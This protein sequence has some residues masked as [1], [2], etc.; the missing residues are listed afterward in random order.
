MP[1]VN[2]TKWAFKKVFDFYSSR[3]Y[4]LDEVMDC[5]IFDQIYGF[6][7][8]D[9]RQTYLISTKAFSR[10]LLLPIEN[11][12]K[13]KIYFY[14]CKNYILQIFFLMNKIRIWDQNEKK[15]HFSL[16]I[17]LFCN[18]SFFNGSRHK[19]MKHPLL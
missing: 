8:S 1:Y 12:T 2:L 9:I 13:Q 10:G 4:T 7:Q 5:H 15:C 6:R 14:N 17:S 3:S 18:P 11:L 19:V 16:K